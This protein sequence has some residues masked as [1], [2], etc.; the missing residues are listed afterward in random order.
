[1][2]VALPGLDVQETLGAGATRLVDHDE[3]PGGELVFLGDAGDESGHLI[4]SA[5]G[6]G[7]NNELDRLAGLPG[8]PDGGDGHE[9]EAEH[10]EPRDEMAD[11]V[12][13]NLPRART[14]PKKQS[15][16]RRRSAPGPSLVAGMAIAGVAATSLR[17][18]PCW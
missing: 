13:V 6:P 11:A 12:H 15:G 9:D 7:R 17:A 5:A 18:R 3:R 16:A 14:L 4:G 1:M 2:G 10:Q 8:R